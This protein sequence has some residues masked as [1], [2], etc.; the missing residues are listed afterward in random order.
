MRKI[1]LSK[2]DILA[3]LGEVLGDYGDIKSSEVLTDIQPEGDSFI[4]TVGN[5]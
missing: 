2:E 3:N 1:T 4:L 5:Y